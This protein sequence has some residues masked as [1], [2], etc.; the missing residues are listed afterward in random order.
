MSKIN[1]NNTNKAK[2]HKVN[3]ANIILQTTKSGVLLLPDEH[4]PYIEHHP[5]DKKKGNLIKIPKWK[6]F[7]RRRRVDLENCA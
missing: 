5:T 2:E 4:D 3:K 1:N 7:G 6:R